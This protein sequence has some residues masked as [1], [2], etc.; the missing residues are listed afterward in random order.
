LAAALLGGAGA[1]TA[2]TPAHADTTTCTLTFRDSEWSPIDGGVRWIVEGTI[3]NT[4][5]APST[6]WLTFIT[7]PYAAGA[8]VPQHWNVTRAVSSP[9]L[10]FNAAWNK[11]IAP[12][13]STTFGFEVDTPGWDVS[14]LPTSSTCRIIS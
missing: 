7:F 9:T 8:T 3:T 1:L 2:V 13:G 6:N 11:V 10:W 5:A 4:G 14:P 12:G